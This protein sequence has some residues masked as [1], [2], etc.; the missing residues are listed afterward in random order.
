M[1]ETSPAIKHDISKALQTG[2]WRNMKPEVEKNKCVGC[3]ICVSY[4]PE[5]TIS[6]NRS[7]GLMDHNGKK[8]EIDYDWCKGCG[9]CAAVCPAKAILMRKNN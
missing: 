8:A 9:V 3:G 1:R 5:A 7:Q 6:I 4:C 2:N